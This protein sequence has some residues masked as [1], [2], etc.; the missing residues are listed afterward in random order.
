MQEKARPGEFHVEKAKELGIP[1]G[2][3]WGKLQKGES[4]T[5]D[6]GTVIE[7]SQVMGERR[8]GRKFSYVTDSLY[9]PSIADYVKESDLLLCEGMFTSDMEETAYEKKHMTSSQA[10]QIA[11]D[12]QVKKLGL[13]HYSPRYSDRELKYLHKDAKRIFSETILTKDRMGFDIPLKS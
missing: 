8:E 7:S 4:V 5:L 10:A 1:M 6:D 2:P 9:L 12:A 13:L 11:K 3:L